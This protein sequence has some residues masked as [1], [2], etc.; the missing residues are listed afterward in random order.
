MSECLGGELSIQRS[1]EFLGAGIFYFLTRVVAIREYNEKQNAIRL[2]R[3]GRI[4]A[5]LNKH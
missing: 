5:L 4:V 1:T 2:K 3:K